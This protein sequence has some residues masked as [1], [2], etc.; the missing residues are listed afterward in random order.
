MLNAHFPLLSPVP[1][2]TSPT[3]RTHRLLNNGTPLNISSAH[4][5]TDSDRFARLTSELERLRSQVDKHSEIL[6]SKTEL[7]ETIDE[8]PDPEEEKSIWNLNSISVLMWKS[9]FWPKNQTW[10]HDEEQFEKKQNFTHKEKFRS[11]SQKW[12]ETMV[13]P[14]LFTIFPFTFV[15]IEMCILS[16]IMDQGSNQKSHIYGDGYYQSPT[17]RFSGEA[18]LRSSF[19]PVL[20]SNGVQIGMTSGVD[21][22]NHSMLRDRPDSEAT[23]CLDPDYFMPFNRYT[24]R[25]QPSPED[26]TLL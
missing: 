23:R 1:R 8:S 2:P 26:P 21:A 18:Y 17:W 15:F 25:A 10:N 12:M 22:F 3:L 19:V 24:V 20:D 16:G 13:C 14:L 9:W 11:R 5:E 7:S 4:V 6:E